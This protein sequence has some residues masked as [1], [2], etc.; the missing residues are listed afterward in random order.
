MLSKRVEIL[1]D[2]KQYA[3]LERVAQRDGKSV[4]ALIR[5]AVER[6]YLH[7]SREERQAALKALLSIKLEIGSWEEAKELILK[8]Y[9]DRFEGCERARETP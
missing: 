3:E 7:A 5:E 4:G 9:L 2:P 1:F 6:E 8:S